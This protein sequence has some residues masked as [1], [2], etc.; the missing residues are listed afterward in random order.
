MAENGEY[1][2]H[3]DYVKI[4]KKIDELVEVDEE[5]VKK[6]MG[7]VAE[8]REID[9]KLKPAM[10]KQ[11]FSQDERDLW[12]T[13]QRLQGERLAILDLAHEWDYLEETSTGLGR[14]V[15]LLIRDAIEE[16][17]DH[18]GTLIQTHK[19]HIDILEIKNNRQLA[20]TALVISVVISYFALWEIFVRDFLQS[21]ALPNGL[22]PALNYVIELITLVPVVIAV[23]WGW[24][25]RS[26]V[27]I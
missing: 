10:R 23:V 18:V 13:Y 17:E 6:I 1:A 22:S 11:S 19:A 15:R 20:L 26:R 5:T 7:F 14:E 24:R 2:I 21:L 16:L 25:W 4:S 9:N 3:N 27:T 12:R 8:I